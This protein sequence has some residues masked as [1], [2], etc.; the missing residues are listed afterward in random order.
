MQSV[1]SFYVPCAENTAPLLF[2]MWYNFLL[3]C[4]LCL[5]TSV[6]LSHFLWGLSGV[7]FSVPVLHSLYDNQRMPHTSWCI[8]SPMLTTSCEFLTDKDSA[9]FTSVSQSFREYRGTGGVS[10]LSVQLLKDL[11]EILIKSDSTE[12]Y[13]IYGFWRELRLL[14]SNLKRNL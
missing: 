10:Q 7:P 5:V 6:H 12:H 2:P 3:D 9:F 11:E 8:W 4:L 1:S 13:L 14:L